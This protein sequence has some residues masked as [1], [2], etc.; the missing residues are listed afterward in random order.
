[1]LSDFVGSMSIIGIVGW[2][3]KITQVQKINN[4]RLIHPERRR[5][6][7]R[8]AADDTYLY[9]KCGFLTLTPPGICTERY[10]SYQ[11]PRSRTPQS[12][13]L[14]ILLYIIQDV[15]PWSS[16]IIGRCGPFFVFCFTCFVRGTVAVASLQHSSAT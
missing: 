8:V 4:S 11:V 15:T 14:Y 16:S 2:K 3:N 7:R 9:T 1:M 5:Q 10:T 13:V 6:K 12:S